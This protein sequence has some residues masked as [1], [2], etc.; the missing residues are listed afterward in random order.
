ML[1]QG[2]HY[3]YAVY[4][5]KSFS[6]A[7]EKLFISQPSL[8]ANVKR[9]EDRIGF[10]IFDRSAKPLKLTPFGEQYIRG[11]EKIM[12]TEQEFSAFVNDVTGLKTGTLRL[13]G[14]NLF[15]SWILPSLMS[16]FSR[17]YPGVGLELV[18]ESTDNL[19]F[20][21][22]EGKIDFM[23]D[24][25]S[26]NPEIY[27]RYIYR[28]ETLLLAVPAA[29]EVN[30]S[31]SSYQVSLQD[32]MSGNF[33]NENVAPVPLAPFAEE[34]FII[35]SPANDT[36]VRARTILKENQIDPPI[37]F[38]LTQQMTSYNITSSGMGI[39]FISDT[40]IKAVPFHADIIYYKLPGKVTRRK[41]SFFW[42]RERYLSHAMSAFLNLLEEEAPTQTAGKKDPVRTG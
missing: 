8:S 35:L 27:D 7:A 1:F 3:I 13:G 24:N 38:T 32:I 9:I 14:S 29:F 22:Q 28:Q 36:G 2:M 31:L 12:E 18:E 25:C 33:M 23:L 19:E 26:L 16:S 41:I 15:S 5:E 4:E 6:R 37:L 30:R 10:P 17:R 11:I 39:S 40:L 34:P 20:L 21:L 42:K